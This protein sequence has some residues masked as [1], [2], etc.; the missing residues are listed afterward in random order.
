MSSGSHDRSSWLTSAMATR[1]FLAAVS[2]ESCGSAAPSPKSKPP[3]NVPEGWEGSDNDDD[4]DDDDDNP[5]VAVV[6]AGA[7][8]KP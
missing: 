5:A 2:G 3:P 4:D 7:K 8:L 6:Q 1:S